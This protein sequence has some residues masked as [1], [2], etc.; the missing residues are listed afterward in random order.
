[1]TRRNMNQTKIPHNCFCCG[2]RLYPCWAA[3]WSR[4]CESVR[5]LCD[6]WNRTVESRPV[7]ASEKRLD[8]KYNNPFSRRAQCVRKWRSTSSA[9]QFCLFVCC[10]RGGMR[11]RV[12]QKSSLTCTYKFM[13]IIDVISSLCEVTLLYER[14]SQYVGYNVSGISSS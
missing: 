12:A 10:F 1:M 5:E 9:L 14:W 2:S 6:M 13:A 7:F 11:G 4:D 8:N 3:L